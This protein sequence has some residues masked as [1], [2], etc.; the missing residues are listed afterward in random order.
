M[1]LRKQKAG[2]GEM[3][4]WMKHFLPRLRAELRSPEPK[5]KANG[6]TSVSPAPLLG[7]KRLTQ[8]IGRL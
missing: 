2:D 3:A 7:G 5:Q 4:E 8:E 6:S 1:P